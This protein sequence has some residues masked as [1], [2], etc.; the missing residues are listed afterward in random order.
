MSEKIVPP[1]K[2]VPKADGVK[3]G[4]SHTTITTPNQ[5]ADGK[6]WSKGS[7]TGSLFGKK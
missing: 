2:A 6:F 4:S 3:Q 1:I 5:A 7:E